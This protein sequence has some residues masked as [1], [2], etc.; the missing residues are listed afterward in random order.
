[1]PPMNLESA[2]PESQADP[3]RES[4]HPFI[5]VRGLRKRFGD[6]QVLDGLDLEVLPGEVMVLLGRSGGGKSVFL[7]HVLGLVRADEG[8]VEIDGIDV[9]GLNERR[10]AVHRRKLGIL[11]QDGALFDSMTVFENVAF[12]LREGGLRDPKEIGRRVREALEV[13]ELAE[14][15]DK[16]PVNLSGGMRK[17][18]ALARAI[19]PRPACVLYDEPTAGLDPVVA[20]VINH[21]IR[22]LQRRFG[23]TS[24]VVTHDMA[25]VWHVADR[26]AY[27][28]EGRVFFQGS[29]AELR[30]HP[31]AVVQD[32]IHGRSGME[33]EQETGS[34]MP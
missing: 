1:M 18:V 19:V 27:I 4:R 25:S 8:T 31:D 20:D 6:Q 17:R 2:A 10:M 34:T 26:V 7:K 29:P 32:F 23:L 28:R 15:R 11:F 21:L 33:A 30:A 16:M 9:T 24:V 13:V 12:P 14:H 5:R 22:R 3:A